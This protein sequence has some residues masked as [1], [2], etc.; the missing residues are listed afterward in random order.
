MLE[1]VVLADRLEAEAADEEP[2]A[3]VPHAALALHTLGLPQHAR[4]RVLP[5]A[6]PAGKVPSDIA[7]FG[8]AGETMLQVL[9]VADPGLAEVAHRPHHRHPG[10]VG[11]WRGL[12][13]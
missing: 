6:L 9:A 10:G 5:Q 2:A 8:S 1:L 13:K 7:W 3:L 4:A 12:F 11:A